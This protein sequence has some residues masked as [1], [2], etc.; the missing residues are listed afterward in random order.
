MK[1]YGAIEAGGTKFVCAI[2][3]ETGEMID[4][5]TIPTETPEETIGRLIPFFEKHKLES[6]GVGSFGPISVD[7]ESADYGYITNTPKLAWKNYPFIPELEKRLGIP[8]SFTTDVNAAALGEIKKGA[9]KGLN[10]C[11]YI[12]VGTGIGAGAIVGG[13]L[14]QGVTHPEMGHVLIR[15]H[16]RD[17]FKGNCPY[18]GE[19][20]EGMAA[21]P[22]IEKRWGKQGKDLADVQEVWELEAD[23]LAQGLMQY[24]LILCPE[25][26][27]MGGGVMKQQHL[28]P[29]IRE[30]LTTYL[31]GY[32]DLPD[33]EQYIVSPGLGDDA[34]ITGALILAQTAK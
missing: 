20:L 34:G 22:A 6:L 17:S 31:N 23:Y 16:E 25:K 30:K 18:H 10:S 12:T 29:L 7:K 9:A 1:Y 26:I 24:I 2:G 13:E 32:L 27:I 33:L 3:T 4:R 5:L 15:R 28:F 19:C 8:V 14:V 21:G 11:L